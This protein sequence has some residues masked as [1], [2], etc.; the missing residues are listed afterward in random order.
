MTELINYCNIQEPE[1]L[2]VA[3]KIFVMS[4]SPACLFSHSNSFIHSGNVYCLLLC[5]K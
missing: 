2:F 1:Y 5:T 4:G 3:Q